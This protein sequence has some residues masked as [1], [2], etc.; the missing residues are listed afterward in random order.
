MLCNSEVTLRRGQEL[1]RYSDFGYSTSTKSNGVRIPPIIGGYAS[2]VSFG[3]CVSI[4]GLFINF[5][6]DAVIAGARLSFMR[7]A[8]ASRRCY[9]QPANLRTSM[10]LR[11]R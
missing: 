4:S 2:D 5:G 6:V 9:Q 3:L 10:S 1:E 8:E 11:R 7:A